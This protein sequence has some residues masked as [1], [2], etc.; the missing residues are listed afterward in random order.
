MD[1]EICKHKTNVKF[2]D[3]KVEVYHYESD[4]KTQHILPAQNVRIVKNKEGQYVLR[5]EIPL[6]YVYFPNKEFE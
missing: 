3:G 1:E 4:K 2:T 6:G 5:L